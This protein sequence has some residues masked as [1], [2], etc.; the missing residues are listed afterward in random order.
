MFTELLR[1]H[2]RRE[3][4]VARYGGEEFVLLLPGL[5][6][7]GAVEVLERFRVLLA[8]ATLLHPPAFTASFGV[9]DTQQ[10][11][12]LAGLVRRADAALYEAKS[13]GRNCIVVDRGGPLAGHPV[14]GESPMQRAM[15]EDE[16]FVDV[17][18]LP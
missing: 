16:A 11:D 7:P 6:A 14:G 15:T 1:N 9:T 17:S 8:D 10:P 4:V 2:V 13:Q 12:S 18:R 3:D 5:D